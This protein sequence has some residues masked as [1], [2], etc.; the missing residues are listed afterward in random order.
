MLFSL[1]CTT[2]VQDN[3]WQEG[4][5]NWV[6]NNTF[7]YF[8]EGWPGMHMYI[9]THVPTHPVAQICPQKQPSTQEMTKSYVPS[10]AWSSQA[11]P[12]LLLE[13]PRTPHS[14]HCLLASDLPWE[15]SFPET[16]FSGSWGGRE[17][18]I[19]SRTLWA[20]SV[21]SKWQAASAWLLGT[22]DLLIRKHFVLCLPRYKWRETVCRKHNPQPTNPFS[23]GI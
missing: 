2:L 17:G 23:R 16:S 1:E 9:S 18:D 11:I 12:I 22:I 21:D 6:I 8:S 3:I 19:I 7:E 4:A 14:P 10:P 5:K 15:I 13:L 20:W